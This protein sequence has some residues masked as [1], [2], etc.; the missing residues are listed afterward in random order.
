[1]DCDCLKCTK[2]VNSEGFPFFVV[3]HECGNK[4]CPKATDHDL[5]CTG[6]NEPGQSGSWYAGWAYD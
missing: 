5:A 6:S 1:M 4:R 3:C 2:G